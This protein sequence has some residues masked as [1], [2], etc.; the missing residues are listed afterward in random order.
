MEKGITKI[1]REGRNT[2]GD[3]KGGSRT[4]TW[5]EKN[6][7]KKARDILIRGD[8]SAIKRHECHV[9]ERGLDKNIYQT[10]V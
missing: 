9:N 6:Y 4:W 8:N 5:G 3:G 7:R 10:M 2:T 1:F